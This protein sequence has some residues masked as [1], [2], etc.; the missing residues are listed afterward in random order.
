MVEK[1]GEDG[2]DEDTLVLGGSAD[3]EDVINSIIAKT[4]VDQVWKLILLSA[5]RIRFQRSSLNVF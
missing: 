4:K 5:G 3:E 2:E 1:D